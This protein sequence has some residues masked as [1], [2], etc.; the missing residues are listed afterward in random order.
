MH[1]NMVITDQFYSVLADSE[2]ENRLSALGKV[3]QVNEQNQ[4][5]IDLLKEFFVWKAKLN[6]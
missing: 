1:S 2:V 5:M 3:N 4:E 6:S